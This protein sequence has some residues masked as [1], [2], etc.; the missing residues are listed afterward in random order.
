MAARRRRVQPLTAD[1]R[2]R[3]SAPS[4]RI[5]RASAL[6][7]RALHAA[8][9]G[10]KPARR[11]VSVDGI[12]WAWLSRRPGFNFPL[13]S[14]D[15]SFGLALD[16][17]SVRGRRACAG[18]SRATWATEATTSGG[19]L[20]AAG[21]PFL[22][23]EKRESEL[24]ARVEGWARELGLDP[25]RSVEIFREVIAMSLKVQEEALLDRRSAERA[26]EN[27]NRVNQSYQAGVRFGAVPGRRARI[28]FGYET[29]ISE[30]GQE[31]QKPEHFFHAGVVLGD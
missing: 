8:R 15:G 5:N 17:V 2:E 30:R 19:R 28:E 27:A 20:K 21:A 12:L 16:R 23:D 29:G 6:V 14:V 7:G 10:P 31:W 3:A 13:E 1:P 4:G 11:R 24:L 26:A 18:T 22:R 9:D 25:F